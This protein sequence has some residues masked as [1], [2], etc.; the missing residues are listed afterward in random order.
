MEIPELPKTFSENSQ[1]AKTLSEKELDSS[2]AK[3]IVNNMN[4]WTLLQIDYNFDT[5]SPQ[6]ARI[7]LNRI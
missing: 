5:L 4:E 1:Q 7:I 2:T 3:A 6:T